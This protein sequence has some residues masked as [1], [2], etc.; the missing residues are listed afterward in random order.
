MV[1]SGPLPAAFQYGI[2]EAL[3]LLDGTRGLTAADAREPLDDLE[4]LVR[5]DHGGTLRT[6]TTLRLHALA[7]ERE[8]RTTPRP[9]AGD[10]NEGT[11][12][13]LTQETGGIERSVKRTPKSENERK[14]R[15]TKPNK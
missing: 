14:A 1:R 4:P 3:G 6:A 11:E 5:Q 2:E 12:V 9:I 7:A 15:A 13:T 8:P 10:T